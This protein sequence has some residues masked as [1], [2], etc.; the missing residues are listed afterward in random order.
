MS[1]VSRT[2]GSVIKRG[3]IQGGKEHYFK[4]AA[5]WPSSVI[6]RIATWG[7]A[8]PG[9]HPSILMILSHLAVVGVFPRVIIYATRVFSVRMGTR[10]T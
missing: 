8:I 3:L 10:A 9:R 7:R 2:N 1:L 6:D 4:V 5:D